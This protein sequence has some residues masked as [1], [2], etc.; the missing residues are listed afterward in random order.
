MGSMSKRTTLEVCDSNQLYRLIFESAQDF[1]IFTTDTRGRI[2]SWNPGAEKLFRY[3]TAEMTG[4]SVTRVFR[5]ADRK[6]HVYRG[7]MAYAFQHGRAEDSRWLLRKDGTVFWADGLLMPLRNDAGKLIGFLKI[8]R[9]STPQ[10][11]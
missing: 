5:P 7:E 6:R 1:A 11:L 4:M 9:D 2:T 8:V 3:S 10:K